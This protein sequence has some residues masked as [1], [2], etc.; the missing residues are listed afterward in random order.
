MAKV[1][2]YSLKDVAKKVGVSTATIIRRIKFGKVK[3]TLKRTAQNQYIFTEADLQ[4]LKVHND[5][6]Y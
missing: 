4:K 6:I 2:G 3:V 5:S 1:K